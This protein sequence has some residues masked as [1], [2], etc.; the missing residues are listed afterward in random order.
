[1][2]RKVLTPVVVVLLAAVVLGAYLLGAR[3]NQPENAKQ[4]A[5]QS[6]TTSKTGSVKLAGGVQITDNKGDSVS[7]SLTDTIPTTQC[8]NPGQGVEGYIIQLTIT[9]TGSSVLTTLNGPETNNYQ[10]MNAVTLVDRSGT[11][12]DDTANDC[13]FTDYIGS[14]GCSNS[15]F[16]MDLSPGASAMWCPQ[17]DFP[18]GDVLA[19]VQFDATTYFSPAFADS[20]HPTAYWKIKPNT[21]F[22]GN[23]LP[24]ST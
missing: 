20:S 19:E 22:T 12:Y 1:M 13:G 17:I 4:N 10:A 7:V 16:T 5:S 15:T 2:N 23:P 6:V 8:N 9:N 21:V 3:H 18:Q 14:A 24:G 11:P